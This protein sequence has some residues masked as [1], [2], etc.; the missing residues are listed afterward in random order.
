MRARWFKEAE[1][2]SGIDATMTDRLVP[3]SPRLRRIWFSMVVPTVSGRFPGAAEGLVSAAAE[4]VDGEL[5]VRVPA[6]TVAKSDQ[7]EV[8]S[9]VVGLFSP[10]LPADVPCVVKFTVAD[11]TPSRRE[12]TGLDV[13]LWGDPDPDRWAMLGTELVD[14]LM[15][16]GEPLATVMQAAEVDAV[17]RRAVWLRFRD[18]AA[19]NAVGK[20]PGAAYTLKALVDSWC[21][22]MHVAMYSEHK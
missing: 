10:T 8:R 20:T 1:I 12:A 19:L 11:P 7:P 2:C 3:L 16:A 4:F 14:R 5:K 21:A 6:Y 9:T 17:S 13:Y 18:D 15:S 22:G